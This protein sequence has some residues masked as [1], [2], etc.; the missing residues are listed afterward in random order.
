MGGK[1]K[2]KHPMTIPCNIKNEEKPESSLCDEQI[3]QAEQQANCT[4]DVNVAAISCYCKAIEHWTI[5]K[6]L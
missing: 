1:M 2:L 4:Y 3:Q 5:A 6:Q